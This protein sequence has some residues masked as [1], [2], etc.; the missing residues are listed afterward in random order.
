MS[1]STYGRR[2]TT[3]IKQLFSL[4]GLV[5]V[6]SPAAYAADLSNGGPY[7]PLPSSEIRV[8]M[9]LFW[10]I[11]RIEDDMVFFKMDD[12]TLRNFGIKDAKREGLKEF[13]PGDLVSVE[14]DDD[15]EILHINRA[16]AGTVEAFDPVKKVITINVRHGKEQTFHLDDA[17][18][19]RTNGIRNGTRVKV[20]VDKNGRVIDAVRS[21]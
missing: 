13:K 3:M 14:I 11:Q 6:V 4:L 16:A 8:R 12:G 10:T 19:T 9:N 21:A 5:M 7:L 2:I 18:A 20:E 1:V 15:N 17:V